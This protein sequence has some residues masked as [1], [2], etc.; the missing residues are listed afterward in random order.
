MSA[1]SASV[2]MVLLELD[3]ISPEYVD[4]GIKCRDYRAFAL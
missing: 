2:R 3:E 4:R 1:R